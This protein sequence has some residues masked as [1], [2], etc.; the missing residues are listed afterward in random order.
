MGPYSVQ[1]LWI[2]WNI[3]HSS[4]EKPIVEDKANNVEEPLV[5]DEAK[6]V[7]VPAV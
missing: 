2:K 3:S 7:E 1:M 4:V 6:E 5:E